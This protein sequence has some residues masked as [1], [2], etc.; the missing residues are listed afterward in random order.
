[1]IQISPSILSADFS[2]LEQ[3]VV[4]VEKGGAHMLHIDVMDGHF[5][6]NISFGACV[7]QSLRPRTDLFFDV[8]LMI[9][10]PLTYAKDFAK[11]GADMITF[12]YE[13]DSDPQETINEIRDLGL[14][15]GMA[16]KPG[17]D[18][19]VL[20][21]FLPQLDMALVMTVEPG[22][23]GQKFMTDMMPKVEYLRNWAN[24]NHKALWIQVDGGIAAST[25]KTVADAG[26][27]V[28][29]AGS[30]VFGAPDR[31][32][33]IENILQAAGVSL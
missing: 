27:D 23:G 21:P 3:D 10:D 24:E 32:E 8:H 22:F 9:S 31:Q 15:V 2:R 6:P 30:A 5:V 25:A 7:M 33:A 11:A 16:I 14:K 19:K 1:M 13:A 20:D 26:A 4:D 28:L 17:T 12:H 18:V 29:V